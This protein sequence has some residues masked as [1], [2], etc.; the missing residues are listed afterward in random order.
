MCRS[1]CYVHGLESNAKELHNHYTL[2]LMAMHRILRSGM[3]A[4][5]TARDFGQWIVENCPHGFRWHVS[6]DVFSFAC[7]DWIVSVAKAAE[8]TPMWIYT[9]SFDHVD[10]LARASNLAVNLSADRENLDKVR[11]EHYW[12]PTTRICYLSDDG[13]VPDLP[14]GS[15][16]FP[17]YSLRG[18]DIEMSCKSCGW[19]GKAESHEEILDKL[20]L[21]V[22]PKC[23]AA[24]DFAKPTDAPW[25][26]SL[27]P[28]QRR[29]VCPA[30]FFGQSEKHRCGPCRK[31]LDQV[32]P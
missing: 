26:Q 9:R 27:T 20:W 19:L 16:I 29:M 24:G 4:R 15:V 23:G 17:D 6:G 18:R 2:N 10:H 5:L 7:A 31:C 32:T 28:E 30:D 11:S 3:Q 14:E 21:P 8:P 1:S 13:K 12:N 22:C 25:W